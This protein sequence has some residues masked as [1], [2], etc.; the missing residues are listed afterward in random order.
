MRVV[1]VIR[2]QMRIL[3][4][5]PSKFVFLRITKIGS[6]GQAGV[7]YIRVVFALKLAHEPFRFVFSALGNYDASKS[8][9][10]FTLNQV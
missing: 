6:W 8:I 2:F 10:F 1:R 7:D 9:H 5:V 3:Y 4:V